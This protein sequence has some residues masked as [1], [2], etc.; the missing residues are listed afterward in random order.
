ME[1]D[2]IKWNDKYRNRPASK[3]PSPIVTE[4]CSLAPEGRALDLAAGP[5][6]NS[7]FLAEKGFT[8]DAVDISDVAVDRLSGRHPKVNAILADLDRY[9]IPPE[10]YSLIL[11]IRFLDRRLFPYIIEGLVPG[12]VV[13]FETYLEVRNGDSGDTMKRDFL[14]RE[15]ELL[16][17]LL[18]LRVIR[19]EERRTEL[20]RGPGW[21]A[22]F[23]GVKRP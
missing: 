4:Y 16:H 2:R 14:L 6:R 12:G 17:A 15:N 10:Q 9:E 5:G 18:A 11:N 23:V 1:K 8:V 3:H 21:E 13:I 19:Y 22:V 7:L 20:E